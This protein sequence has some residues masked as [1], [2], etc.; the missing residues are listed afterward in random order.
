M[1][2]F[3]PVGRAAILAL[4]NQ[5]QIVARDSVVLPG[6]FELQILLPQFEIRG[7]DIGDQ[8]NDDAVPRLLRRQVLGARGFVQTPQPAP[9]IQLPVKLQTGLR[10]TGGQVGARRDEREGTDGR[11]SG[12]G[13]RTLG[14]QRRNE[15]GARDSVLRAS[16][17]HPFGGDPDIE[18]LVERCLHQLL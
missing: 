14:V 15:I 1:L 18:V 12:R 17:E 16:F 9:Q 8:R 6:D 3:Q 11:A 10:V 5:P 7:H 2:D 13:E 4:L